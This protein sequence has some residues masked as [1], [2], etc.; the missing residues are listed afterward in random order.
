MN[1]QKDDINLDIEMVYETFPNITKKI[2]IFGENFVKNNKDK[3]KILYKNKEYE[4]KKYFDEIDKTYN[5]KDIISFRLKG[6]NN[7]TDMSYMFSEC[8]SFSLLPDI[9]KLNV[10]K[11]TNMSNLFNGC[12]KL[13]SLPDISKWDTS[14]VTNMSN[15][16]SGC[17]SIL[18]LPDISKWNI[19]NVIDI[20]YIFSGCKSITS[21]PDLSKWFPS[22]LS[23]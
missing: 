7:I 12:R 17:I 9:S 3:C 23:F 2:K 11:V 1:E 19:K 21:L 5:Y 8:N 14:N 4:L 13:L 6:F 16:F 18:S 10:S 15:L 22:K 20:S